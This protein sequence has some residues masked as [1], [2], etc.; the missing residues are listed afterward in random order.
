MSY[1][2]ED[3]D[4][5][6]LAAPGATTTVA[7]DPAE[8]AAVLRAVGHL[9]GDIGRVCPGATVDRHAHADRATVVVGT[10]GTS[11][12]VDDAVAD[13]RLDV[14]ALLDDD[15]RP[16]WE[17]L[18]VR[19]LGD[20]LWIVGAD[21]RGT[22]FG[23]YDLCERAGVSPW[24]WFADVPVRTREHLTV[25]RD[26]DH[27]DRPSVRY[28]GIFLND[29]EELDT[30]ARRHTPDGTIGP[31][32]YAHVFELV[33]RLKGN[34]LWPA[35]HV[36]AFNAD[37]ENGRLAHEAGIVIGTSHCDMLLRSNEHEWAPW[38]A[39]QARA[40]HHV[41]YDYSIEG[42]NR[43]LL[44]RY[45]RESIQQNADYEVGWTVG[46][47]GIHDSG[48]VTS[49]IDDD[50]HLSAEQKHRAR[51][52][53]LNTLIDDQRALLA[54]ELGA[55]RAAGELQ[56]FVPYKEVLPL[57]D[58]G[59][60]IPEDVTLIWSDDSF[61]HV[62]RFPDDAE[63]GR[64]GGHGLYYHSSYWSPP[65]R[66][67]LFISSMP[68]TLMKNE[69]GKA[70]D[71]GIRT[72]WVN[73]VG[74]LKPLE[75][76]TEFFLRYAWE[77]GRV[78]GED[79]THRAPTSTSDVSAWARD[80]VDRSFSGGIG[81]QVGPLLEEF[82]QVTDVR[83]IEHLSARAF[84]Q[85]AYGDEAARRLDRL[86]ELAEQVSAVWAQLP[87]R[88]RDA[89]FQL[90]A[91]KVHASYLT[92]AQF[93]HADRSA[94]AYAQ[95]K[96]AAAD[97]HLALSRT[98]D[99]HKR[100]MI[101]AYNTVMSG[102][103][104]D[105]IMTPEDF[106]PPATALFPAGRPALQI[107][108]PGLGVVV[109]GE[110]RPGDAPALEFAAHGTRS[111]WIE[112]FTTGAGEIE[113][114]LEADPWIELGAPG[115]GAARLT[116]ATERRI[117]VRVPQD[118]AD[119]VGQVVVRCETDG[120]TVVVPVRTSAPTS[121]PEDGCALE[122]DGYVS[123]PA[124]A[125]DERHD[126]EQSSWTVVPGLGRGGG[127]LLEAHGRAAS[128]DP[129]TVHDA[130][131]VGFRVHLETPGAHLL[132]LFRFPGLDSTGRLR[133]GVSVDD[134]PPVLVESPT[135]DEHRGVWAQAVVENVERL[136]LRL[137]FL[138]AGTHTVRLHVVDDG[139]ALSALVLWTGERRATTLAPPSSTRAG[140]PLPVRDDPDP[141][142]VDLAAL[143]HVARTLYG[144]LP[145]EV[146]PHQAVF[147]P[148]EYWATPTTFTRNEVVA[149]PTL[150]PP[151]YA[152]SPDGTQDVLARLASG[153]AVA[154]D[155]VLALE[156]ERTLREEPGAWTTPSTD[157]PVVGWTHTQ[158][159]TNGRTGLAMHVDAPGRRWDDA[160]Q[161][162]GLHLRVEVPRPGTYA[163]W[164]L[165]KFDADSDDALTLAVDGTPLPPEDQF[166][167]GDMF[168]FGTAQAWVW[169]ELMDVELTAG[170]HTLSVLARKAGLRVDRLY[171]TLGG[172]RPPVD[173]AWTE[174]R[175]TP[176]PAA[177]GA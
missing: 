152:A 19:T 137:P 85:T 87:D 175:C 10:L 17:A 165:V 69:L 8:T 119:R 43:D 4:G 140:Q 177:A 14:T 46:M 168:S 28:R 132:E 150:G 50:P 81:A 82:A 23:I 21:R 149:Q 173:A 164:V 148:R 144:V 112:V 116:V 146:P 100:A 32:L 38:A 174:S 103:K 44:H 147:V 108:A 171:L 157:E 3:R 67:Y 97:H 13:G 163:V 86:R 27:T 123:L 101:R 48:F 51:V 134:L 49:R 2:L 172:E 113:V 154:D 153:V 90:V 62:R 12:W 89:F 110:E 72:L 105:G 26:T 92:N 42:A 24:H 63:R 104:W 18:L 142:S 1:V 131:T 160:L 138:G 71:R 94:L 156:V 121:T 169:H 170:Q 52:S 141:V 76:D 145:A 118:A 7:V 111:K 5:T 59:V 143:D 54:D 136:T 33:L 78:E 127:G 34:Y 107:G 167:G 133:V 37:P 115:S 60:E 129:A 77:V 135:T 99:G 176:W 106:P 61:G 45:W 47:R 29:E 15:G 80:W 124:D 55:E 84:S 70:W 75:Q 25:A 166:C 128:A 114:T 120:S 93:V 30:W 109:W 41:E 40:G 66:S 96:M 39:E 91:L 122:A 68:L 53:L 20:Q 58:D 31:T 11:R 98:F 95:G 57:Y 151:R 117:A 159:E 16:A 158:A 73:N 64:R 56:C 161:A 6:P 102:G 88:E 79:G 155:G 139:F 74:A 130:G 126:T 9:V 83:K 65:P 125:P 162:P 36:N 35:M 22:V